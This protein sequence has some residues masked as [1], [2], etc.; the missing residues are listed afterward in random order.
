MSNALKGILIA[1]AVVAA[2]GLIG[3]TASFAQSTKATPGS[4]AASQDGYIDPY[5]AYAYSPGMRIERSWEFS[6]GFDSKSGSAPYRE[7][8]VRPG[9]S[10][11]SCFLH[12]RVPNRC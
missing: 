5:A 1:G 8:R 7:L 12:S 11:D 3:G 9:G 2:M 6:G 10:V 4:N